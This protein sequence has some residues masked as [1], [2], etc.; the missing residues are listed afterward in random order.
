MEKR[1]HASNGLARNI[2][3]NWGVFLFSA[4][5]NFVLSPFIVRSLGDAEY[6]VWVLLTTM[7]GHLGLLDLGVRSALTRYIARFRAASD[8]ESANRVLASGVRIFTIAGIA[9]IG[10]SAVMAL[11]VGR[12]FRIPDELVATARVVAL[13]GGIN[14]AVTLLGGVFGGVL[15]GLE[16]FDFGNM[17]EIVITA[18]RTVAIVAALKSGRGLIALAVIQL[19]SSFLGGVVRF[20]LCRVVYPQLKIALAAWDPVYIRLI[21]GYGLSATLLHASSALMLYSDTLVI[22][23]LLP[24]SMITFFAIAGSLSEYARSAVTGISYTLSPRVSAL[25]AQGNRSAIQTAV[26]RSGRLATLVVLPIAL[27]FL[28]RGPSFIGLWMGPSYVDLSGRVL[29]V[30]AITL[31]TL[32]GYQVVTASVMGS[33]DHA[34]IIPY[35]ITEAALNLVLSVIWVKRYGV[36]GS[37]MGT[38]VPRLIMSLLVGPWYIQRRLGVRIRAFWVTTLVFPTAA[39][40]P[41]AAGSYAV[42]RL[43]PATDLLMYFSQVALTLPL[44]AV[45]AWFICL[46]AEERSYI[47]QILR[48]PIRRIFLRA[49]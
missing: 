21:F 8:H 35:F 43:W 31:W 46:T 26:L 7:V 27:T 28:L 42:E 40:L 13:I 19:S 12:V 23:A 5:I 49:H 48:I 4:T 30:L 3:S 1:T 41:F 18:L 17:T 29:Q 34:G 14:M 39:M 10:A 20:H 32:A 33:G 22:G 11:V 44:A 24:A 37:A 45:G 16:R 38:L 36:I 2:L 9:A 15:I 25:Q 6:G 47:S